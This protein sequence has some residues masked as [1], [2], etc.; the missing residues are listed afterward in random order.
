MVMMCLL[1]GRLNDGWRNF[2]GFE[3][4]GDNL[5]WYDYGLNFK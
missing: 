4:M 2:F 3:K 1:W 5:Y